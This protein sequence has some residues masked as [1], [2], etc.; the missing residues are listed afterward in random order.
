MMEGMTA[1]EFM[2]K[3][4]MLAGRIGFKNITLEDAYI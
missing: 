2:A 3:L 1:K 4:G